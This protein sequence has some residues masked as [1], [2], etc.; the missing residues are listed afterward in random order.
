MPPSVTRADTLK[1]STVRPSVSSP[2][3]APMNGAS[4]SR[5]ISLKRALIIW[6]ASERTR[7]RR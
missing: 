6:L 2:T 1:P 4:G 3:D 7:R 5:A